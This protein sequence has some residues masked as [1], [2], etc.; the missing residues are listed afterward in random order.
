MIGLC[1]SFL[2]R[3]FAGELGSTAAAAAL[4]LLGERLFGNSHGL[5]I[6]RILVI[7]VDTNDIVIR[8]V[9]V[10]SLSGFLRS[11]GFRLG[12]CL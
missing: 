5:I 11:L 12:L 4:R 1:D 10:I 8:T 9:S 2:H 7:A 3:L 6:I